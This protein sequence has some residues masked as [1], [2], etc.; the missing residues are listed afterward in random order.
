MP[1]S[2]S[3][4]RGES[5]VER[6]LTP[7][8][9]ESRLYKEALRATG[10]EQDALRLWAVAYSP[11]FLSWYGNWTADAKDGISM[12]LA[13]PGLD[14]VNNFLDS[15][16]T[17]N[18][19]TYSEVG[20]IR[21]F[22]DAAGVTGIESFA[23]RITEYLT[24]PGFLGRRISFTKDDLV[25][26]G[27]Y[28]PEEASRIMSDPVIREEVAKRLDSVLDYVNKWKRTYPLDDRFDSYWFTTKN[29]FS[30]EKEGYD[31]FGKRNRMPYG[32]IDMELR[33]AHSVYGPGRAY[34]AV[35]STGNRAL[36]NAY[37][38]SRIAKDAMDE[39]YMSYDS[40]PAHEIRDG[41]ESP[42]NHTMSLMR[43]FARLDSRVEGR[44]RSLIR[45]ATVGDVT[46]ARA[47]DIERLAVYFGIDMAGF[48]NL[49]RENR[50]EARN[51]LYS[52]DV[53]LSGLRSG[54]ED[55]VSQFAE[56]KERLIPSRYPSETLPAYLQGKD[57]V[58]LPGERMNPIDMHREHG[59]LEVAPGYYIRNN[60]D[61]DTETVYNEIAEIAK[62]I[63]S[64]MPVEA[65]PAKFFRN[66]VL[67]RE[68]ISETRD[69]AAL[70]DAFR[71]YVLSLTDAYNDEGMILSR[72][73][74]GFPLKPQYRA[75]TSKRRAYDVW[76]AGVDRIAR[77]GLNRDLHTQWLQAKVEGGPMWDNLFKYMDFDIDGELAL[78]TRDEDVLKKMR[79]AMKGTR[80]EEDF[81]TA[82][83]KS[84][85][86]GQWSNLVDVED[87]GVSP[88]PVDFDYQYYVAHP[89]ELE[90]TKKSFVEQ[91]GGDIYMEGSY[92]DIIRI[93]TRVMVK[94]GEGYEGSL[95]SSPAGTAAEIRTAIRE[96]YRSFPSEY[97]PARTNKPIR[98][99]F[100]VD[101]SRID[102]EC[103]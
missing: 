6:V 62:E 60:M 40:V 23:A 59:L 79:L 11:E 77:P 21:N 54:R 96:Q 38:T 74:M 72:A 5:G 87:S 82:I 20:E 68:A 30:I 49:Y 14:A 39:L 71:K 83:T 48:A 95:Y 26:S 17:V 88:I 80:M 13:E 99:V 102:I 37:E 65:Y 91:P 15:R 100:G 103:S 98:D 53:A 25:N 75:E 94:T 29:E 70:V 78:N 28:T 58:R 55:F 61:M 19:F 66:G 97:A 92:D 47:K 2:C 44:L 67:D 12:N 101:T 9:E 73:S 36:I 34:Q 69:T 76:R 41:V 89:R 93:G 8:G 86:P 22:M 31:R 7:D 81:K 42:A 63:P 50:D 85:T 35:L 32:E 56:L 4:I 52:L 43:H 57:L 16:H 33:R 64:V 51:L 3:I 27:L 45:E 24:R 10:V 90:E 1:L 46:L 84:D 18:G